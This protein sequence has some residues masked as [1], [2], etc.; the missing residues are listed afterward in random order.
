MPP[1]LTLN[2]ERKGGRGFYPMRDSATCPENP[3]YVLSQNILQYQLEGV[4]VFFLES[5]EFP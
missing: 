4:A 2:L 3:G 1:A 5:A